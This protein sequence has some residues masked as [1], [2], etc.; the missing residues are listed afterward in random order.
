MQRASL[1]QRNPYQIALG[2]IGR[3]ADGL[4][5][6]AGLA[7]AMANATFA[8]TDDHQGS[9]AETSATFDHLGDAVDADQLFDEFALVPVAI[10]VATAIAPIASFAT[11]HTWPLLEGQ[12][13][14][15]GGIGQG[16]DPA[17]KQIGS[18]V[19]DD[20][21]DTRGQRPFGKQLADGLRRLDIGA[22]LEIL[23]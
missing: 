8:V 2:V 10:P 18:A 7:S 23:S 9:K 14:L 1:A 15:A 6:L 19:E 5:H 3:L 4:G 17:M 20:L 16:L 12:T 22:A 11:C 21:L 13:A